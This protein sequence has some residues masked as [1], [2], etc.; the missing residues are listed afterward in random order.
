MKIYSFRMQL[1]KTL[2]LKIAKPDQD[3]DDT[4]QRYG[5][6]MNFASEI[7]YRKQYPIP[8]MKLQHLTYS[9]LRNTL[10]LKSQISCNIS[11]QVACAY[12]SLYKKALLNQS[13]WQIL[14][15]KPTS[16]TLSY[17]RDFDISGD[18]VGITTLNTGSKAVSATQL[19]LC[20]KRTLQAMEICSVQSL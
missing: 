3:L 2:I 7:A 1:T 8:A 5:E 16:M 18:K 14:K 17:K 19:Q 11:R 10:K 13:E 6:G 20:K 9:H 4:M 15:F 12:A